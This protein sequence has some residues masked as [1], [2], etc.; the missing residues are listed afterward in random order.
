[1]ISAL[2]GLA[3]AYRRHDP[4][5][6]G[7]VAE[8]SGAIRRWLGAQTFAIDAR[9]GGVRIVDAQAARFADLD[10]VQIMGLVEGEWPER[11]R[12]NI[13]YPRALMAELEPS[14]PDRVDLNA[15]RDQVRV[16]ARRVS[17]FTGP[18]A[19]SHAAFHVR[20]RIR[21]RGRALDV[22]RRVPLFGLTAESAT[23]GPGRP[24][25]RIRDAD[26]RSRGDRIGVGD[27][28]S[29]NA[30][31]GR[32]V[33]TG[34][35][36]LDAAARQRQPARAVL[37]MSVPVLRGNVLQVEEE[38]EDENSRS[39]L[40][41]GRFLHE[42]F[43]TFFHEWQLRGRGRITSREMADARALFERSPN[44]RCDRC[45]RPKRRSN[46]RVCLDRRSA[47]A[48]PIASSRWRLN[49]ASRFA[50]G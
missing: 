17:R 35:W 24:R 27:G 18:R 2:D 41:R 4:D 38:P 20:A 36:Q 9:R 19:I 5:A 10:E 28:T 8:L 37:E 11:P 32:A 21:C 7:S 23:T 46:A 22:H 40:Q 15:E 42:L 13:F 25:V 3:G 48:S 34:G 33:S 43:E 6:S 45:R 1:M 29:R 26:R 30:G 14:R 44:R 50:N 16:G 39:P 49:A 47:R 12:R 31:A